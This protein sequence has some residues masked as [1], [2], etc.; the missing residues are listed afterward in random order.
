MGKLSDCP[1]FRDINL[2]VL[3]PDSPFVWYNLTPVLSPFL[4]L[5]II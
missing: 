5:F 3:V 4:N 2:V 1:S